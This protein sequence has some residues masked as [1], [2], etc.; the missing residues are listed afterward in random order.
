MLSPLK[1]GALYLLERDGGEGLEILPFV[2]MR[3][4]PPAPTAC[5]FYSR[6]VGDGARFVS[7]HQAEDS[8]VTEA[9]PALSALIEDLSGAAS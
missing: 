8:E 4:G 2:R 5:Y 1:T 9:D 3:P 6:L 7:Y